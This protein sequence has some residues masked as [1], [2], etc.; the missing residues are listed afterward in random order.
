MTIEFFLQIVGAL[1]IPLGGGFYISV[2]K[3]L[4]S[5]I[6]GLRN[7]IAEMR[8]DRLALIERVHMLEI[9]VAENKQ[10][11]R[12]AQHRIDELTEAKHEKR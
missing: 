4:Q 6:D 5:S 9:A 2:I 1:I 10:S 11:I 3:P 8:K 7:E 12:N